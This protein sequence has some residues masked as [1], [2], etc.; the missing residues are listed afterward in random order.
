M[1]WAWG[2]RSLGRRFGWFWAAYA[3]SAFG[4][5]LAFGAFPL[6]AILVLHAGPAE[7]AALA[8]AGLAVGAAGRGAARAVG[9]VP[10]QA[11]GDDRDGPDPVRG[12]DERPRRVRARPARASPSSWLS[13]SSSPRPTSPSRAA[14]GAYL[15][16]LVPPE[17]LLVANGRFESTTWTATALGPPLGGAAIGL[18]GPVT[19]VAGQRGQLPALGRWASAPSAGASRIP[20]AP[21]ARPGCGPATCSTDGATSSPTRRCARCSSTPSWSTA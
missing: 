6:I 15:K 7:V 14:S 12:A 17:D 21:A 13:R 16:A 2:R 8:A 1:R 10:P 19:T 4:T 11:A 9:G 18:L 3:V 20:R 5:W